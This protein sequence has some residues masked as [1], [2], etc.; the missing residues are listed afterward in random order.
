MYCKLLVQKREVQQICIPV[1]GTKNSEKFEKEKCNKFVYK[2][3]VQN[4]EK[5][6]LKEKCDK[7]VYKLLL[8]INKT[9]RKI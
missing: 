6:L 7:F 5:N 1:T 9:L 8:Q 3:P 4:I 2:L